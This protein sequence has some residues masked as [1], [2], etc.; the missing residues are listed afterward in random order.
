MRQVVLDTET[1]GLSPKKGD[2]ILEVG[3]VELIDRKLTGRTFHQII[4]PERDI[5]EEVVRIHN[6]DN[7]RVKGCPKFRDIGD[8]LKILDSRSEINKEI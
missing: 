2:R 4:D 5:P 7:E 8:E 3:C 1:T 6:I